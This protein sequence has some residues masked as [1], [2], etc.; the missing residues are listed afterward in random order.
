MADHSRRPMRAL[1][2]PCYA[3]FL[4]GQPRIMP[5]ACISYR[6][7]CSY[8]ARAGFLE[9]HMQ[10]TKRSRDHSN[11]MVNTTKPRHAPGLLV[12]KRAG[13]QLRV[14]KRPEVN[15]QLAITHTHIPEADGIIP[16]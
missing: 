11:N 13:Q 6:T 3:L 4:N 5:R 1:R 7:T 15:R 14:S 16:F 2:E 10:T 8:M 9:T 12:D